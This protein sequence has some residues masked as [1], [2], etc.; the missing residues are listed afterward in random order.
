MFTLLT[1]L[2]IF[3]LLGV[4]PALA[5]YEE[6]TY[7][8]TPRGQEQ[9]RE[10]RF[11]QQCFLAHRMLEII[12]TAVGTGY[13]FA[14]DYFNN[15]IEGTPAQITS[16]ITS[17]QDIENLINIKPVLLSYLMPYVRIYKVFV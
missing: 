17:R 7:H 8:R 4:V 13:G 12:E 1:V 9:V 3:V 6:P 15:I 16:V 14:V 10:I 5:K 11:Q 2:L